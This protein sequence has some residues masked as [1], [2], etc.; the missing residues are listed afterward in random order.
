MNGKRTLLVA[1]VLEL[2][3]SCFFFPSCQNCFSR[4]K[5]LKCCSTFEVRHVNYRYRLSLK[6]SDSTEIFAITVFGGCLEPFFGVTAGFLQRYLDGLKIEMEEVRSDAAPFSLLTQAVECCFIGK[7]FIFGISASG[8]KVGQCSL[9]HSVLHTSVSTCRFHKQL[10]A[11]QIALPNSDILGSTVISYYKQ[12][13][14]SSLKNISSVAQLPGSPLIV[15]DEASS[16][17]SSLPSESSQSTFQRD[18]THRFSRPWQQSLEL[19]YSAADSTI[20]ERLSTSELRKVP[21]NGSAWDEKWS[22]KQMGRLSYRKSSYQNSFQYMEQHHSDEVDKS[23]KR[24]TKCMIWNKCDVLFK[25]S[26]SQLCINHGAKVQYSDLQHDPPFK[27]EISQCSWQSQKSCIKKSIC[28]NSEMNPANRHSFCLEECRD[29]TLPIRGEYVNH[30]EIPDCSEM[31]RRIPEDNLWDDLPFSESLG[32]FI[33]NIHTNVKTKTEANFDRA[34]YAESESVKKV[35]NSRSP[36]VGQKPV[37]DSYKGHAIKECLSSSQVKCATTSVLWNNF[38]VQSSESVKDSYGF[39]SSSLSKGLSLPGCLKNTCLSE[40]KINRSCGTSVICDENRAVPKSTDHTK[41]YV[42]S[43][44]QEKKGFNFSTCSEADHNACFCPLKC[45]LRNDCDTEIKELCKGACKQPPQQKNSS[46]EFSKINFQEECNAARLSTCKEKSH[47]TC[48]LTVVNKPSPLLNLSGYSN[49]LYSGSIDLFD[50]CETSSFADCVQNTPVPSSQPFNSKRYIFKLQ[51]PTCDSDRKTTSN[52]CLSSLTMNVQTPKRQRKS[53]LEKETQSDSE[54]DLIDSQDFVPYSQSTPIL[55]TPLNGPKHSLV[56]ECCRNRKMTNAD[57]HNTKI[58][59]AGAVLKHNQ[60]KH[61]YLRL[62]KSSSLASKKNEFLKVDSYFSDLN[63]TS[64]MLSD[65]DTEECVPPSTRKLTGQKHTFSKMNKLLVSHFSK[66]SAVLSKG[67]NFQTDIQEHLKTSRSN[68]QDKCVFVNQSIVQK[69]QEIMDNFSDPICK[70]D[71]SDNELGSSLSK[72][73]ED[74][75][76]SSVFY[77]KSATKQDE[78]M[79]S[80][81]PELFAENLSFPRDAISIQR[82]LF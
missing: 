79:G 3:D 20:N 65:S 8:N 43:G 70:G 2:Q 44:I 32:E 41:A 29:I 26:P 59:E 45:V 23:R 75:L 60:L 47:D 1:S 66:E 31:T 19:T 4:Y 76:F 33:H 55:K 28:R 40:N 11:S 78:L 21:I 30:E 10:I 54:L 52:P 51:K 56:S 27:S 67:I 16:Y 35:E 24:R 81:S 71:N 36:P 37:H 68:Q 49:D 12:L 62:K 22:F 77:F 50:E 48:D 17:L 80:F 13:L 63:Y 74:V 18:C 53:S 9:S 6:V 61:H 58:S 82:Q 5:C 69:G 72:E 25:P 39:G 46:Y 73:K 34:T 64:T 42:V 7:S 38:S 15:A 57:Y 14:S